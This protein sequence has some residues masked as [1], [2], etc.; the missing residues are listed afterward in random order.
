M[1][2]LIPIRLGLKKTRNLFQDLFFSRKKDYYILFQK[3][4]NSCIIFY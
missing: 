1:D 2:I 4:I 3:I